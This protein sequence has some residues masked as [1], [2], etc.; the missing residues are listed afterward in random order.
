MYRVRGGGN[1]V[2]PARLPEYGNQ[3]VLDPGNI[4]QVVVEIRCSFGQ[5]YPP[6]D[7]IGRFFA[8]LTDVDYYGECW[9]HG[10]F[11]RY[12]Q[13]DVFFYESEDSEPHEDGTESKFA[14][15]T[16]GVQ[17]EQT[18]AREVL[19]K[20]KES[21]ESMF[22]PG[23]WSFSLFCLRSGWGVRG[24]SKGVRKRD[25]FG[26]ERAVARCTHRLH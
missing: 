9:Q 18:E 16:L 6:P 20:L 7:I 19:T 14:G 22:S 2:V 12:N 4:T 13:Q 17:A 10:A 21:L 5:I 15:I 24:I 8:W 3:N 25:T 11:L 23:R 26:V 1:L